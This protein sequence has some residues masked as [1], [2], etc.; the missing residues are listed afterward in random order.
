M[1]FKNT[2]IICAA[3]LLAAPAHAQQLTYDDIAAG[4][5][6][7]ETVSGVRSMADG[8][9]YSATGDGFIARYSYSDGRLVDT[10][11]SALTTRPAIKFRTY[12]LS[13]D[14]SKILLATDIK[15]VYRRSFTADYY[16]YD[17]TSRSLT[18]LTPEG[19]EQEA[20]FSPDGGRVAYVRDNNLYC[21][22]LATGQTQ[23]LT[24]DGQAGRIIN[25]LTDWVYEEEFG[26]TRA[27]E[28]SPD[29]ERIAYIRFDESRVREFQM[30]R[31][32]DR[33]YPTPYLYKYPVAGER[34]SLATVWV[35]DLATGFTSRV[36]TDSD[37]GYIPRIGWTPAGELFCYRTNRL[38]NQFDVLLTDRQSQ[39]RIVYTESSPAYIER[40]DETTVTF[41]PDGD[42]FVVRNETS[43]RMHLYMYSISG[44]LLHPITSGDWDV[45]RLVAVTPERIYFLSNEGSPLRRALWS[46]APDGSGKRRLTAG[47]GFYTI[48]PSK[49]ARYFL[50]SFSNTTT[51]TVVTLHRGDGQAVRTLEDNA[52]LRER[53]SKLPAKEFF[54]F[55]T[56]EGDV[57]NGYMIKPLDFN[58]MKRYPVL[59]TQYSGPGSQEVV[60]RW[61]IDW[62]DV[63]AAHGYVVVCVDPRGTGGRGEA[64]RKQ[65]YRNLGALETRDQIHA[66]RFLATQQWVDPARIGI[67]GWSYGGFMAL[68]CILKGADLFK[69]AIA[70]APVTSW[71]FYDTIY[72]ELYNGLPADNAAGYDD[73][74]P[75]NF[76]G[77]LRGKLLIIHGTGDDNV[78]AV[79]TYAMAAE[80]TRAGRQFDMMLYTDD[81]HS[82]VPSGRTHVRQKMIDYTLSNL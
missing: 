53:A 27:F 54:K 24:D 43:G 67:Y 5:Y 74:S 28:F 29:G 3:L 18:R 42:R 79:N 57:L 59:M 65:T 26:F 49:G 15:P 58:P 64:F 4:K 34:N 10:L 75:L 11:F 80:L 33:L 50:S 76:A 32:H 66:A 78:H 44:G 7:P 36:K 56:P 17:R 23:A 55:A 25:G 41:L 13:A 52:A 35:R 8:E 31:Y 63:L 21:I 6:T 45:V 2:T 30:M 77:N 70:V 40:V 73:N 51:P 12:E 68:N 62:E 38:Q 47:E 71:R 39:S 81:N 16:L 46:I 72:T 22:D 9:H 19:G 69:M 37:L 82:M 61:S 14:E 1:I 48:A 60:D 20:T